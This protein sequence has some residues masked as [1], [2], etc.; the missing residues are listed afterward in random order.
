MDGRLISILRQ[1]WKLY[2]WP[3]L[4]VACAE[5]LHADGGPSPAPGAQS[6]LAPRFSVGSANQSIIQ[7]PIGTTLVP[8]RQQEGPAVMAGP[9]CLH[10]WLRLRRNRLR[11]IV[12][13][14]NRHDS[15]RFFPCGIRRGL[16][17]RQRAR[18]RI[19][20]EAGDGVAEEVSGINKPAQRRIY[21]KSDRLSVRRVSAGASGVHRSRRSPGG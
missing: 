10:I 9:S 11:G 8:W 1:S 6:W 12:S 13:V 19:R 21:Y 14:R 15:C 17:S 7:S 4:K 2:D 3:L 18:S 20:A 5:A 16:G